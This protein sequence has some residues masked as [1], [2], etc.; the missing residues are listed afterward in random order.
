MKAI[1]LFSP[2]SDN[3][4]SGS[5]LFKQQNIHAPVQMVFDLQGFS[6]FSTH[7]I[8]IHEYGDLSEGCK[9]L[10]AHFNPT[11]VRHSHSGCGHAGD[12]FNNFIT[13]HAGRFYYEYV[14]NQLTLFP[15]PL[16]ILGRSVVIH[17]FP[18]DLGLEGVLDEQ[19]L[20]LY[21]DMTTEQLRK[22]NKTLGYPQASREEMLQ[23]LVQES[24][25]TGNASTRIGGAIIGL[26]KF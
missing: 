3:G 22:L 10:G 15:G 26:A 9:S 1:A 18:D 19:Y 21:K 16:C 4:I 13:D 2:K 12:L 6:A 20:Y 23:K 5:I 24:R 25:T 11:S 8:H 17:K 7:A 14:S